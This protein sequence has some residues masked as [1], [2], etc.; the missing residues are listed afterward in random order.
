LRYDS[1]MAVDPPHSRDP[2][3]RIWDLPVRC[4]HW[5]LLVAV[6]GAWITGELSTTGF[7]WHEIFGYTVIVLASFRL[8][9]GIV[10]T[11]HARFSTFLRGP[12]AVLAYLRRLATAG[13]YRPGVGHNPA[14][15]WAVLAMLLCLL[16]EGL[17]GLFAND[18]VI[19]T[20][21][22]F[23]WVSTA[24]SDSL[25]TIHHWNFRVLQALVG[26]HIA[27]AVFYYFLRHDNLVLPMITGRKSGHAVPAA[28]EIHGSRTWL[29]LVL[30]ILLAG[31]LWLAVRLAPEASL[32]MF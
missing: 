30:V 22:L 23:G 7:H 12:R 32:S 20:G 9:W 11:R 26:L 24:L 28:E 14:G 31:A 1:G 25:T 29:A 5:L 27:A 6:S 19:N 8:L 21:P 17:T 2:G 3:R 10:G 15:G 13:S 18:E 16:T 4:T